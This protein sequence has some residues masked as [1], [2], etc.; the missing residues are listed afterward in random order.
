VLAKL[1]I[2]PTAELEQFLP[3]VWKRDETAEPMPD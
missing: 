2:T 3:D 1:D